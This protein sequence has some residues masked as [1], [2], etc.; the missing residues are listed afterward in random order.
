MA[1][2]GGA[3]VTPA[4]GGDSAE[5]EQPEPPAPPLPVPEK[6]AV[7]VGEGGLTFQE[8]YRLQVRVDEDPSLDGAYTVNGI[9]AIQLGYVG[10]VFLYN[11]TEAEA[12]AK[13]KA[14]LER[15][16]FK[17][18]TVRVR[19]L[20]PSYDRIEV[21]GQVN[22]GAIIKIGPDDAI[23]I[24]DALMWAGGVRATAQR[25]TVRIVRGGLMSALPHALEG[26]IY[27]LFDASGKPAIPDVYLRRNDIL[28]VFA[29]PPPRAAGAAAAPL[30][31]V[32]VLGEVKQQG[33]FDFDHSESFTMM[34]LVLKMGG[35]PPYANTKKIRV[36]RRDGDGYEQEF[37]IDVRELLEEGNPD[38]DFEFV[39]GDRIVVPAR[40]I[41]LF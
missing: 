24:R 19:L 41:S 32:L 14:I 10:P 9:G 21:S 16:G 7:R 20:R 31:T 3:T 29:G 40:R 26:E 28:Q 17:R 13:I 35:F 5:V 25:A 30:R 37:R 39:N 23:S 4:P 34:Q 11:K 38:Y 27:P 36:L 22:K 18:A 8:D 1:E 15:R 33:Y 2:S 6:K 12:A